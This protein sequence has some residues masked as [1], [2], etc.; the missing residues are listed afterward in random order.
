MEVFMTRKLLLIPLA[1]AALTIVFAAPQTKKATEPDSYLV[2]SG[3]EL[4]RT[5]CASCHGLDGKGGGPAAEALKRQP[6]DLTTISKRNGGKFPEFRVGNII[7]GYET[8]AAHGTREMPVWGDLLPQHRDAP[9]LKL[10]EHN[11]TEY[12][13]SLQK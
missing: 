8:I 4:Y 12:V 7:D 11:L 9:L 5:Y 13:R 3:D 6:P 2:V 10:R 1:A